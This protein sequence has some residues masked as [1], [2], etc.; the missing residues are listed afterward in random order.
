MD[1][2]KESVWLLNILFEEAFIHCFSKHGVK[3]MEW[4]GSVHGSDSRKVVAISIWGGKYAAAQ[5]STTC[6]LLKK[7]AKILREKS[8]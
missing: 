3:R 6:A 1:F 8:V 5:W 4:C 7:F 2:N